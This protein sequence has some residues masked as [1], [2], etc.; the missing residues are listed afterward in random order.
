MKKRREVCFYMHLTQYPK[1]VREIERRVQLAQYRSQVD[2]ITHSQI[3][4]YPA[5]IPGLCP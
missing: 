1:P 5:C 4:C 2:T 3:L